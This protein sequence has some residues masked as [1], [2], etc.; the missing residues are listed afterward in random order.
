M[1]TRDRRGRRARFSG[2]RFVVSFVIGAVVLGLSCTVYTAGALLIPALRA[3][4][5]PVSTTPGTCRNRAIQLVA[6]PDDDLLFINPDIQRDIES[7]LCVRTVYLTAGDARRDDAYWRQREDGARAAYATMSG[8]ADEWTP[9]VTV[10]DGHRLATETLDAAPG[11]SLVFMRLPDGNRRGTG[12]AI[13][14][15]QSLRR[16][17]QGDINAIDAVDGTAAYD[18]DGL[19]RTLTALIDDYRPRIVRV[20]DWTIPFASGDNADHTAA[21]LFARTAAEDSSVGHQVIA[22]AGYPSWTRAT[23]VDGRDLG[24]KADAI[25]AYA[26]HDPKLCAEARCLQSA[27]TAVRAGRQYIVATE[28]LGPLPAKRLMPSHPR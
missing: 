26:Q 21:A 12:N 19:L 13:R 5:V 20:Q 25:I 28:L 7:G 22:Y 2:P 17:W 6:H 10:V 8:V 3:E 1:Q 14:A 23:N 24:L 11:I 18:A 4:A 16:L 15:Y 27:V 9:S